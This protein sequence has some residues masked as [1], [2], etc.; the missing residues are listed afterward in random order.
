MKR[1]SQET[2]W[3][4][5]KEEVELSGVWEAAMEAEGNVSQTD[6]LPGLHFLPSLGEMRN[7]ATSTS[8]TSV[9]GGRMCE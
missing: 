6:T 5:Q 4:L 9:E 7:S 8:E 3:R 1:E 2:L